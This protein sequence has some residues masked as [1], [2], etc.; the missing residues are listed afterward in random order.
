MFIDKAKIYIKAGKGGNGCLSFRREKFVPLGGP[1]GGNGGRGGD[2]I[3][4]ASDALKTL[5]DFVKKI[6][7]KAG[8]GTHGSGAN[9]TG[10]N[11]GALIIKVPCGTQVFIFERETNQKIFLKDLLKNNDR[12]CAAKGGRGGRGNAS[13]KTKFNKAPRIAELGEGGEEFTIILE[14]KLIADVG[15]I[16]YPNAGKSTLLSRISKA[17]PKIADY[18]FTTLTPNLGVVQYKD[19]KFIAADIPGIIEGA[20]NGIGLGF[21][22][23]KHIE[24]TKLL[25][26][27]I[28]VNQNIFEIFSKLNNELMLFSKNLMLKKQIV[29][30]NKIDT[31]KDYNFEKIEKKILAREASKT[32]YEYDF[33]PEEKQKYKKFVFTKDFEIEK[34][35]DIFYIK[36]KKIEHLAKMTNF[37]QPDALIRFQNILKKMGVEDELISK[38]V[39]DED[40]VIIGNIE[41]NYKKD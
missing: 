14:L 21:D 37:N 15:I 39:Q 7:F 36:G 26:H 3:I 32:K 9:K 5:Y 17:K 28:D 41:F 16:G 10:K 29:A 31:K 22:F 20:H 1:D 13:F 24:R 11:G 4:Q 25:L 6:H 38:G 2:V 8:D 19:S 18:P 23:L 35:G 33:Q 30:I 34:R 40:L 27:I 12:I